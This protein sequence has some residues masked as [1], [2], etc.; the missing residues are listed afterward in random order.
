M[1]GVT[2]T[3]LAGSG[4]RIF[5]MIASSVSGENDIDLSSLKELSNT[6]PGG[7]Q[8][9]PDGPDTMMIVAQPYYFALTS[10]LINVYWS[11]AQA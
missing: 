2:G 7:N 11:E 3:W 8:M 5:S 10:A 4:E 1:S 9:F 6:V